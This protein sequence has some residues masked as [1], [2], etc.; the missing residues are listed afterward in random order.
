MKLILKISTV[1]LLSFISASLLNA[2]SAL[3]ADRY[4]NDLS[5][6]KSADAY[7]K[8]LKKD[9]RNPLYLK[10]AANS[11]YE[12]GNYQ[13]SARFFASLERAG[14]LEGDD[15]FTYFQILLMLNNDVEAKRVLDNNVGNASDSELYPL[16]NTWKQ[17]FSRRESLKDG[18]YDVDIFNL[19]INSKQA[20][21]A[22]TFYGNGIVFASS[23]LNSSSKG[24]IFAGD[25]N[26]F[27]DLYYAQMN[28][29]GELT[30]VEAFD[31]ELNTE[32]HDGP[33][34]FSGDEQSIYVSRSFYKE[35]SDKKIKGDKNGVVNTKIQIV[36]RDENGKWTKIT[37]F[38]YNDPNN[39]VAHAAIST[40]GRTLVY[41]SNDEEGYGRSDLYVCTGD[42]FGW[43]E[44][45]NLGS[46]INT[47]G[48]EVFPFINS[49]G[50]LF[51]SS[52]G[53]LGLGGLDVFLVQGFLN[54]SRD[55]VNLGT[56]VNS[57]YDDFGVA[58]DFDKRIG[59][60]SSNREGGAGSDDIYGFRFKATSFQ[61]LVYDCESSVDEPTP[62][63]GA[64]VKIDNLDNVFIAETATSEEG[65]SEVKLASQDIRITV[66]ADGYIENAIE[67]PLADFIKYVDNP[68]KIAICKEPPLPPP[69]DLEIAYAQ[70]DLPSNLNI[71]FDLDSWDITPEAAYKLDQVF[72][73]MMNPKYINTKASLAAHTDSRGQD[74]YNEWL[75]W[76][77]AWSAIKYLMIKGVSFERLYGIGY[78]ERR[79]LNNC[80]NGVRCSE[81]SHRENR[82][83][84]IT[85]ISD[86]NPEISML[87]LSLNPFENPKTYY[88]V[89]VLS[90]NRLIGAKSKD[91]DELGYAHYIKQGNKYHHMIGYFRT[92][93]DAVS[94]MEQ[95]GFKSPKIRYV[96]N[97]VIQS[98]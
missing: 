12:I 28:D 36:N 57:A 46:Y 45:V 75:S 7:S 10:R 8:L 95:L 84:D 55:V 18:V 27:L 37:E 26:A 49:D 85:N 59:F 44:P 40:D 73:M 74:E 98:L 61:V 3:Q 38:P 68:L 58:Y 65:L 41:A 33:A 43:S 90:Y 17:E 14:G 69:T 53:L 56:P 30:K 86:K 20:D 23:R 91:R 78:G 52:N 4:W 34:V 2:Q 83:V 66:Q 19:D 70:V 21:F 5:Y 47:A 6:V 15:V 92:R 60:F 29:K 9:A 79:L 11:F 1:L 96:E 72:D 39:M 63:A 89:E 97:G 93:T 48:E 67:V 22:P 24:S 35:E 71:N 76:K 13:S 42:E 32:Y 54:G 88:T 31:E 50:D 64:T 81:S 80:G 82:R 94:F 25:G 77:R 62:I 51:F 87:A 16:L